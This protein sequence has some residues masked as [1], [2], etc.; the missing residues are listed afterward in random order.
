MAQPNEAR[1]F[2]AAWRALADCCD[3][4]DGWRTIPI[5]TSLSCSV[6]AGRHFPGNEEAILVGFHSAR[7][8]SS[9]HLPEGRGFM[10]LKLDKG[11]DANGGSWLALVRQP[12]GSLE[13]FT[14]M[15][16]DVIS[17]L[18][19]SED[20][21]N[22]GLLGIFLAR[23]K[24]WQNFMERGKD[25][26]LSPE[27]EIGLH[28][29]L[30][31]LSLLLRSGMVPHEAIDAWHGPK[32]GL[33]DFHIGKGA[34]EVK[35]TTSQDSFPI[36]ISSLDQIDNQLITLLYLAGVRLQFDASGKNLKER[37]EE[38]EVLL[39]P[40]SPVSVSFDILLLYAGYS[41]SV[42]HRYTRQFICSKAMILLVDENFPKLSRRNVPIGIL[43][44]RYQ[45]DL[46][47]ITAPNVSLNDALRSLGES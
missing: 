39:G 14:M 11:P 29:E 26:L 15:A 21:G 6:L 20:E 4:T 47:R 12:A 34:I 19:A 44:A 24:A 25:G 9:E 17:L 30:I 40:A 22:E 10:V 35:T 31:L 18:E 33:H 32:D 3:V 42:S 8:P 5:A 38:I 7:T 41:P 27:A 43:E 13:I 23:I 2:S 28:G 16:V 46:D 36:V 37:V 1:D 45:M